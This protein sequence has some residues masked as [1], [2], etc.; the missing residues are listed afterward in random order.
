MSARNRRIA[1]RARFGGTAPLARWSSIVDTESGQHEVEGCRRARRSR[2]IRSER[3][4]RSAVRRRRSGSPS[5]AIRV[6]G[7]ADR[8]VSSQIT[9][10]TSARMTSPPA[11]QG[12]P[13]VADRFV[14][15][16]ERQCGHDDGAVVRRRDEH[17]IVGIVDRERPAAGDSSRSVSSLNGLSPPGASTSPSADRRSCTGGVTSSVAAVGHRITRWIGGVRR[18]G[19]PVSSPGHGARSHARH[20]RVRRRCRRSGWIARRR[21][22]TA[23]KAPN[24]SVTVTSVGT[25]ISHRSDGRLIRSPR[26]AGRSRRRGGSG[27]AVGDRRRP[28]VGGSRCRAR[29]RCRRRRSRGPTR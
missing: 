3:R 2:A 1:S 13:E 16:I 8:A 6:T 24:P 26:H 4:H 28:C 25:S 10:A 23:A 19:G 14:E 21:R 5:L 9:P 15:P 20:G 22:C 29:R 18:P 12:P 27:S 11:T 7:R 17:P